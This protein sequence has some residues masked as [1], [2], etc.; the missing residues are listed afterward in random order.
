VISVAQLASLTGLD[1]FPAMPP[2]VK[3]S[4]MRLPLP[5]ARWGRGAGGG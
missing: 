5:R 2:S 1:P 3:E 4:A